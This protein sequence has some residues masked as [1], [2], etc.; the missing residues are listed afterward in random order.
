M[1]AALEESMGIS[2]KAGNAGKPDLKTLLW[3][4]RQKVDT[5]AG[6][7][8]QFDDLTMMGIAYYGNGSDGKTAG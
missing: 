1:L 7:A 2:R 4:V 5:F 3:N 8:P 6:D